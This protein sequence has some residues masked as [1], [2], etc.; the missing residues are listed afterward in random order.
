MTWADFRD[1]AWT[2][3]RT[4]GV[5]YIES[6]EVDKLN[7]LQMEILN[8]YASKTQCLYSSQVT[9]TPVIGQ[10]VY[11]TYTSNGDTSGTYNGIPYLALPMCDV[12]QVYIN[13]HPLVVC[14]KDMTALFG[15]PIGNPRYALNN[16][17]EYGQSSEWDVQ[18][19][20]PNYLTSLPGQPNHFFQKSPNTVV[21]EKPFDQVYTNCW[22]SG[23]LYHTPFSGNDQTQQID[24]APED[25]RPAAML[26]RNYLLQ[27]LNPE[28][29]A[30]LAPEVE[31]MIAKRFEEATT[32]NSYASSRGGSGT[33]RT[34]LW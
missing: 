27:P 17:Y 33:L 8:V 26:M 9:F 18:R 30:Q 16:Q 20:Y 31:A 15:A 11:Q 34:N 7:R 28:K 24:F 14:G 23:N 32:K 21:F 12:E 29:S 13:N 4:I 2:S 22:F 10:S 3:A 6:T 1:L 19:A 25:I 5:P